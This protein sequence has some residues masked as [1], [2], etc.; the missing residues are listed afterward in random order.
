MNLIA[1]HSDRA[2]FLK[3]AEVPSNAA[4][5][6]YTLLTEVKRSLENA[7]VIVT[8]VVGDNASAVQNA[9]KLYVFFW[10]G[11]WDTALCSLGWKKT[12]QAVCLFVVRPTH[13][14]SC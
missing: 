6:Y 5:Q 2:Y 3:S 8:A 12:I 1:I 13:F 7:G 11:H 14:N 10:D 9:L 4:D